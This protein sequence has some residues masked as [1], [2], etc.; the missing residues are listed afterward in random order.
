[1]PRIHDILQ[2]HPNKTQ[3]PQQEV[4]RC[5]EA[6]FATAQACTACADACLDVGDHGEL[7]PCLR[8]NLDCADI[9]S[10]AGRFLSRQTAIDWQLAI[11]VL[12][13]CIHAAA[14]CAEECEA[15]AAVLEFC[16]LCLESCV[17]CK[18]ACARLMANLPEPTDI[19]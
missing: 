11:S 18:E 4:E 16:R 1:M 13:T 9:A 12:D 10:M 19:F 2:A 3:V 7:V 15:H 14:N 6:C 8:A 17:E 5:I